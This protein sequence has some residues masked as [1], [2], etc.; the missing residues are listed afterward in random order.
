M[1]IGGGILEKWIDI[2]NQENMFHVENIWDAIWIGIVNGT[3]STGTNQIIK[4][5]WKKGEE[6]NEWIC[7]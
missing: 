1:A 6:K 4:Q 5:L 7:K 3:S 2:T